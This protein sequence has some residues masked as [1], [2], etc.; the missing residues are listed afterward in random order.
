MKRSEAWR[1]LPRII[2]ALAG[3]VL[4]FATGLLPWRSL[5]PANIGIAPRIPGTVPIMDL[6]L[7]SL[8]AAAA[9]ERT[10]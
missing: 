4:A 2:R 6:W 9:K 8:A 10:A 7:R 5:I 1:G 3:G